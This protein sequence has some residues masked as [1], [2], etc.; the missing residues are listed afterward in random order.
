M[1]KRRY[2]A[3]I[4]ALIMLAAC[5]SKPKTEE[6]QQTAGAPSGGFLLEPQH[7]GCHR[8]SL[9]VAKPAA[10]RPVDE[11]RTQCD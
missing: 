10:P 8:A 6:V 11:R 5:S 1:V 2:A 9:L 4:P 3:L 7:N